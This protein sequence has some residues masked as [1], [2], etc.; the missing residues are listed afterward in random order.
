MKAY[1]DQK[2]KG[3]P[4]NL[5][6]RDITLVIQRR[7]DKASPHFKPISSLYTILDAKGSMIIVRQ[8]TDQKEVT[9]SSSHFKKLANLPESTIPDKQVPLDFEGPEVC[10][11]APTSASQEDTRQSHP[12]ETNGNQD[13]ATLAAAEPPVPSPPVSSLS[14]RLIRKPNWMKDY[15]MT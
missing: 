6:A 12:S 4:H 9:R 13:N 10:Q 5:N 14:G 11:P 15:V 7:L 3:K 8:A 1:A 2:Q